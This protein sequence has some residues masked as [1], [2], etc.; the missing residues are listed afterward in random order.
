MSLQEDSLSEVLLAGCLQFLHPATNLVVTLV[1]LLGLKFRAQLKMR[2]SIMKFV[3]LDIAEV[4]WQELDDYADRMFSQRRDWLEFAA[5]LCAG[6]IIIA[7]L[8]DGSELRGYF[9]GILFRR[10]GVPILGSPFKGW[11]T[12]YMGFNLAPDVSRRDAVAALKQF[13]FGDLGCFH[14]ELLD[15]Y[16]TM[17]D[18]AD[19][20][21]DVTVEPTY[22]SSLH[23]DEEQIF[24]GMESS[25]RRCIRKADKNGLVI[26]EAAPDGFSHEYYEQVIEVFAKQNLAPPYS[27]EYVQN[28]ID[29][30]HP[31]GNALLLRAKTADGQKIASAIYFGYQENSLFW[32]NGSLRK[33][34]NLRPNEA[35]HWYALKY[36]KRRGVKYHDWCGPNDY[37]RKF[38]PQLVEMPRIT[39]SRNRAIKWSRNAALQLYTLPRTIKRHRFLKKLDQDR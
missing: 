4:C 22:L 29:K 7:K 10:F 27:K 11:T 35:L 32:G 5:D 13:A 9:S 34:Q 24:A 25:C 28:L 20:D 39:I 14:L 23:L 19:I 31:S 18:V 12:T 30:I 38:G 36:W 15:R 3:A 16:L 8:M 26:E 37:K 21:V 2:I 17:D 6:K 33:H 1:Q